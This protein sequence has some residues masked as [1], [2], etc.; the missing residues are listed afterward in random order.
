MLVVII[1]LLLWLCLGGLIHVIIR[2]KKIS[3]SLPQILIFFGC[4]I[5][6]GE[7]Y[8]YIFKRFYNGDDTWGLNQDSIL[9]YRRLLQSPGLFITDF[10]SEKPV[11]G[12]GVFYFQSA[13]HLQNLEY[14]IITKTMALFNFISHGNYYINVVFLIFS[15]SGECIFFINCLQNSLPVKICV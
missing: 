15:V 4:K 2:N 13:S 9:Q 8:G 10:F 1:I 5:I 7:V 3:L 14:A 11:P 12:G 6:A